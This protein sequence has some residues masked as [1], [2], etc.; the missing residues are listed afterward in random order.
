MKK[1]I[2]MAACL[3]TI[4][5][6]S[7][8]QEDVI[9]K[10]TETTRK[11]PKTKLTVTQRAQKNVD[12]LNSIV[13]LTEDQKPKVLAISLTKAKKMDAVNEKYKNDPEK[14]NKSYAEV[15]AIKEEYKTGLNTI[16]TADQS[17]KL[18]AKHAEMKAAGKNTNEEHE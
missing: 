16:L 1:V 5:T 3:F 2:L 9:E 12:H 10:S 11:T 6:A 7:Y 17:A 4:T 13:T 8:A 15:Q 14:N 18:K